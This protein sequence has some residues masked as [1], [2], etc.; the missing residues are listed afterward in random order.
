VRIY[1]ESVNRNKTVDKKN[2]KLGK[3]RSKRAEAVEN[4]HATAVS[5]HIDS[6]PANVVK[7]GIIVSSG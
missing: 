4:A 6:K 7:M 1:A 2:R 5:E 3:N